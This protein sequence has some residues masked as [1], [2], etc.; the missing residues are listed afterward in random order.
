MAYRTSA[1]GTQIAFR[2]AGRGPG[3]VLVHGGF[4]DSRS[5]EGL[6]EVLEPTRTVIAP[7]RRGHG[8]SS[9]YTDSFVFADDV[10]DLVDIVTDLRSEVGE[11][12]LIGVSAGA[13]VAL[14]AAVAGAPASHLVLW[15]PPDFQSTPLS[16]DVWSRLDRAAARGDRKLLMRLMMDEVVGP[17]TG[18]RIPRIVLPFLYRSRFGRM[19]LANALA[20]PTGLRAFEGHDWRS[21]NLSGIS[22][23]TY[24]LIGST[25]PAFNRQLSDQLVAMIPGAT[26][27]VFEGGSHGTPMDQ[28][29]K[30]AG[31]LST[32]RDRVPG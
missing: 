16:V 14:A 12:E 11:V 28:P 31:L 1:D 4:I 24:F 13:H 29:A 9:R 27:E 3:T 22:I 18:M 5:W 2:R 30:F 8:D 19:G 32:L 10:S 21:E 23:P 20:I 26:V 17:N 6:I 25:S 15:E 7:D